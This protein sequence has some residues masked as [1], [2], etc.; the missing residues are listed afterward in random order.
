VS[1]VSPRS[2]RYG[3]IVTAV[4]LFLVYYNLLGMSRIW[5]EQGVIPQVIGLWWVHLVFIA[6]VY[7]L[8]NTNRLAC[9]LRRRT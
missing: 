2:G 7:V 4:L 9:G 6:L 5:V 8:L 1:R 3:G